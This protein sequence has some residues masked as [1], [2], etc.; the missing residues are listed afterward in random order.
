MAYDLPPLK[1]NYGAKILWAGKFAIYIC[2]T[3][4]YKNIWPTEPPNYD[5]PLWVI[6]GIC[7]KG[8]NPEKPDIE[9][10]N[11]Y[12]DGFPEGQKKRVLHEKRER[13]RKLIQ[14]AKEIALKKDPLLCCEICNFSFKKSYNMLRDG[15]IEAHHKTP[16]AE[17][18]ENSKTKIEDLALVCANCHRMLHYYG[19]NKTLSIEELKNI[20]NN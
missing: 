7:W 12:N 5:K 15:F 9:L 17:L 16:V 13:N 8:L 14:K 6:S 4:T 1:D 3:E 18:K 19:G 20:L 10:P 2:E 11:P